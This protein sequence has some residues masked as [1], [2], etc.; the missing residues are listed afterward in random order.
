M[1]AANGNTNV[2][3]GILRLSMYTCI[4]PQYKLTDKV[5]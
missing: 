2:V 1:P 5:H 3:N 4:H